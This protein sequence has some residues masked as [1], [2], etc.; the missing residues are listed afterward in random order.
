MGRT[1]ISSERTACNKIAEVKTVNES[2]YEL[3]KGLELRT[4]D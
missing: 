4:T 3:I 1:F 2:G